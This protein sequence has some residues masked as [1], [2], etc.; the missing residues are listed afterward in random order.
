M[1]VRVREAGNLVIAIDCHCL[2]LAPGKIIPFVGDDWD[3]VMGI[4]AINLLE[5]MPEEQ[6]KIKEAKA[7]KIK[8]AE[9]EAQKKEKERDEKIKK[10][11]VQGGHFQIVKS[12][13]EVGSAFDGL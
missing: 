8:E 6:A 5:H 13:N 10:E 9:E 11:K 1:G 4:T 3:P 7:R 12:P 2:P